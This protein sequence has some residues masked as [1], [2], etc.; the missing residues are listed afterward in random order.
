MRLADADVLVVLG[1]PVRGERRV[2]FV[3]E[4]ACRVVGDVE[5][6]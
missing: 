1:L 5:Q 3:V 2:D 4:L 6:G